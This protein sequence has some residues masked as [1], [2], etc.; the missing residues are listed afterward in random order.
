MVYDDRAEAPPTGHQLPA[1][2]VAPRTWPR[3]WG[4]DW[5]K[6]LTH[7]SIAGVGII[8]PEGRMYHT[9][10]VYKT[11][12]RPDVLGR[13]AKEWIDS[14][15]EPHPVAVVCDHD[16]ANE[17]YQEGF[18]GASGLSLSLADKADR[19][20][21]IEATQARFDRAPDE[22][23]TPGR[24]RIFFRPG[25]LDHPPDGV[26]SGHRT[27]DVRAGRHGGLRVRPGSAGR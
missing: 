6:D 14:G 7:R 20:K 4:I 11:R 18:E 21:G 15:V 5:G 9:R 1:D 12:L 24:A 8:D 2:F 13:R 23:G 27:P 17:G 10:E 16:T 25:A 26:L 19:K 22:G 3:V